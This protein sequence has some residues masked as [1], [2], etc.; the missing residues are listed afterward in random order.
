MINA[1]VNLSVSFGLGIAGTVQSRIDA[2]GGDFDTLLRA[3][4]AAV[5]V[6]VALSGV[7]ILVT[8]LFVRVPHVKHDQTEGVGG[9]KRREGDAPALATPDVPSS[10]TPNQTSPTLS[11]LSPAPSPPTEHMA[12]FVQPLET[13]DYSIADNNV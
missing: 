11:P 4:R 6:G 5:W 13:V 8:V 9:E 2:Q 3:Q 1:V 7:G 10:S 12:A